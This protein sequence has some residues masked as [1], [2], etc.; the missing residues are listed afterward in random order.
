MVLHSQLLK[1]WDYWYV[2]PSLASYDFFFFLL[3]LLLE[4]VRQTT[5]KQA[6]HTFGPLLHCGGDAFKAQ[7]SKLGGGMQMEGHLT[8][9]NSKLPRSWLLL[10]L[11]LPHHMPLPFL[12]PRSSQF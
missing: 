10:L 1:C 8:A 6:S 5:P 3:D 2:P 4:D 12:F 9:Y 11:G 7:N